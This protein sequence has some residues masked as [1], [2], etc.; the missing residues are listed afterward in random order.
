VVATIDKL[1][2]SAKGYIIP[3]MDW[4]VMK[5]LQTQAAFVVGADGHDSHVRQCLNIEY[6]RLGDP[7]FFA[8]YEFESDATWGDEVR[9]VLDEKTTNVLWPLSGRRC[10]W[11]F[12][13]VRPDGLTEFPAK[14]REDVRIVQP[15]VDVF[16]REDVQKF[17]RVRAPWFKGSVDELHWATDVRFEHG[18][19][20]RFGQD[21]CW[22]AGDAA[23][24]TGPVGMQ[25]INV[26]LCEAE[27]L[28]LTLKRILR[29]S[30]SMNLLGAYG[31]ERRNEWQR[32]L[33]ITGGLKP[34]ERA[35]AWTKQRCAR[36]LSCIPASGEDLA[37][38]AGQV[39]LD[40]Q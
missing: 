26:G 10:R 15:A 6:E 38:L 32:L 33:G 29:D 39:G 14:D 16:T 36:M 17:A 30:G 1:G 2:Q 28:A 31:R 3:E 21:H 25:S 24:Q 37:S 9:I 35:D 40:F 18:L 8:V 13:L 12:Q 22:L 19:A 11:S 27:E 20:K 23:H 34:R 7:E 4:E 5:T